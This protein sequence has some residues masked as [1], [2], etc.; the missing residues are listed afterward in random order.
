MQIFTKNTIEK[1]N[2]FDAIEKQLSLFDLD[3][4][5]QDRQ[6]PWG[7][8]FVID[9]KST[10]TFISKFFPDLFDSKEDIA[11]LS[12]SPK[13]LVVAPNQRLSW[14]YHFRRAEIWKV[15]SSTN[16]GVKTSLTNIEP[17]TTTTLEQN[18]LIKMQK[19][20][21]HRLIGLEHWG[22]V[23]EIWHH[24]DP[25]NPSDENDIVRLQDDFGR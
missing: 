17:N 22:I 23:A 15:V 2:L 25:E 21:R 13:I 9:Q 18:Q 1:T 24:T 10:A 5:E 16:V 14:Q 20:E 7:G 4:I 8:F 19:G 3:W 12:I 11:Q 6:R